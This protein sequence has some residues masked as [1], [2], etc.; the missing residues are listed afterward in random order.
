MEQT[1]KVQA[2]DPEE[3]LIDI[4][5]KDTYRLN[6]L[7]SQINQGAL[8]SVT[9]TLDDS[10]G[11][12]H[13][14]K[15]NVGIPKA[16]GI[17]SDNAQSQSLKQSIQKTKSSYDDVILELLA[18]LELA[19]Q[20]NVSK[21]AIAKL[22]ILQGTISLKNYK[23]ISS[24]IPML[25]DYGNLMDDT[26]QKKQAIQFQITYLK[27]PGHK[28]KETR[29]MLQRLEKQLLD[30]KLSSI[31]AE[32]TL[33]Q[34]KF[35]MPFLPQGVGLELKMEN[36]DIVNGNLKSE[37]LIDTEESIFLNYNECLP[38]VW[39]VLGIVD[40]SSHQNQ[41]NQGNPLSILSKAMFDMSQLFLTDESKATIIPL[42]I[43]RELNVD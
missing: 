12:I 30:L 38:G 19:P 25:D 5:Y 36:G 23:M 1:T 11:S 21:G 17:G 3:S 33:K 31:P 13:S 32:T 16:L 22:S 41:V 27:E 43:Y 2:N 10:Q 20:G 4:F 34:M 28:T 7:V 6:S 37:Y 29:E 24:I 9:T 8:Q 14:T 15:A 39:N 35:I 26:A 42:L 18:Q 40:E